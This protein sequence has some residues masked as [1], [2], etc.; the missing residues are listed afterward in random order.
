MAIVKVEPLTTA[1]ALRGPFDYRL[2][3]AMGEVG[4]GSVLVVPFGR[5]RV[6]GVVIEVA[7][8]SELPSERLA[9]PIEALEAGVPAELVRLGLW[10][11]REYCSTPARGL[12]LVLPP[13]T[14]VGGQRVRRRLNTRVEATARGLAAL[15]DGE[16]LGRRQ[17][18]VLEALAGK[19]EG[20]PAAAVGTPELG[21]VGGADRATVRR[22]EAR[23]LVR[24]SEVEVMRRPASA[25]VGERARAVR[26]TAEQ[27]A[28]VAGIVAA[29]DGAAGQPRELLLHGV[30]GSGKTEVYLAAAETAMEQ[31][32][33]AIVLVPEIGLTPQTLSRFRDRFG[34]AVAL[35][36]SALP[37]G[38][39]YDEW[40]RL[41]SG[42]ARL[43]VGPRSAI[44]APVADLGLIVIDEEH[45]ASYKQEGDPRYDARHVARRRAAEAGAVL[46]CGSAT[47]R[48]ESWRE[49]ARVELPRRVDG[50]ELPQVEVL[51]MRGGDRR[52]GP[53]HP[54]TREALDAVRRER[55]KA[56]VLL[57]RRGWAPHLSCRACGHAWGCP[58]CD[59]SLVLHRR[60]LRL[61]C[62]HCGHAAPVPDSCPQ[63]GSVTL[64][65]HGAGTERLEGLLREHVRGLPVLRLDSD[66][67]AVRGGHLE[68]LRRFQEAEAGILLG[69]QMVAKGH[70]FAD[71][72]LSVVIDA[73][74]SLRFPDFRAEERTFALIAQLAGRSG[75]G[76]AGGRVLVQTL[77]PD[78]R[79]IAAAA[80][81]DA[82]GF[83]AAELE[84]RRE[85]RYP[86]FSNLVRAEVAAGEVGDA[87]RAI[88]ELGSLIRER[89]T[90]DIDLLGPAPRFRR[91][92]RHRRQLL[93]KAED[94][95]AAIAA[96]RG[97]V[98]EAAAARTLRGVALSVDV[99]PQ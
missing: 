76:E 5:R 20:E 71:V 6:V 57:N 12:G 10:A 48:P 60:S 89:L 75:R 93:L 38:S 94:R 37:P 74:A 40:E 72:V 70:D 54:R 28:G 73:D 30:T 84:R 79:A 96:V 26:L 80:R 4:V 82:P 21:N 67:A 43:C 61:A 14:G 83:L 90:A 49:L 27:S 92:S 62:H 55:G 13:G 15:A 18:A 77:A 86:P 85:L 7:E 33:G 95:D 68:I 50:R 39:R 3:E 34:D 19:R 98:E 24:L 45:D 22:L 11:A 25:P 81:H 69:T 59:V 91:R 31:R 32:R 9:E 41:R 1:R 56:I 97:A 87:E 29:L 46:V 42:V 52:G 17:R 58:H 66:S 47:P 23:G 65:R 53:L 35:L 2:P 8:A 16:R 99:D 88:G 64:A 78:A 51:D 63:C 36:H 44:F